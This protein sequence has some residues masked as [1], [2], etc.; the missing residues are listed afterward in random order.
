MTSLKFGTSGLRGLVRDMPPDVCARYVD[1]FLRHIEAGGAPASRMLLVGRDLRRSSPAIADACLAAA[2]AAGY[3]A[4]DCGALPTPALALEA[5]RLGVPAIMVTGSHIPADRNGLK[6][7][8]PDGEIAKADEAGILACLDAAR[9]DPVEDGPILP[10]AAPPE[11]GRLALEN[12]RRRYRAPGG[13]FPLAGPLAG[14][15][16]GVWQHSSVARDLIAEVLAGLGAATV[17]LGRSDTFVAVDTE[18]LGPED[19]GRAAG[20]ARAHRVDAIVSSDG[21]AD[22]PLIADE[23]GRF[24]RGD[25]VGLLTALALGADTVVTPVT[26]S[27]AVELSGLFGRTVRT[28]VGS[29]YV[30][31]AMAACGAGVVVGFEANGGVLLGSPIEGQGFALAALPT[32]DALLPIV[33]VLALAR[34]RGRTVSQLA[35]E[36]PARF[37]ASGRME[38]VAA[39]ESA[40][41]LT[42]L[43]DRRG[44]AAFLGGDAELAGIDTMDGVRLTLATGETVHF[45]ASGNAPELRCY[46]EASTAARASLLLEEGLARA[47]TAIA[48]LRAGG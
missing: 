47:S 21:D 9:R 33:A 7:Y 25:V 6:F 43:A 18:A 42:P 11:A 19:A 15:R 35:G 37:T 40:A 17:A 29:P 20:W 14:M 1:A 36:M 2:G 30:I 46:C 32:R 16:V 24:L 13:A 31:E 22:R 48:A 34:R 27:S 12:Y 8:R 41:L 44:A 10:D 5:M 4:V 23:Q 39:G 26:S 45:R 38:H 3:A 28:R